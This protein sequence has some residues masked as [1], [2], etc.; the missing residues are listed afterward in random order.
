MQQNLFAAC[1]NLSRQFS[2]G[3]LFWH[4]NPPRN[5]STGLL[6]S[7]SNFMLCGANPLNELDNRWLTRNELTRNDFT[8]HRE[9]KAQPLIIWSDKCI[10]QGRLLPCDICSVLS[11][12]AYNAWQLNPPPEPLHPKYETPE[13]LGRI[14]PYPYK[15]LN[16]LALFTIPK[17]ENPC[18]YIYDRALSLSREKQKHLILGSKD[19][20]WHRITADI[21][22]CKML[23]TLGCKPHDEKHYDITAALLN[24]FKFD[25]A[26]ER[27][28]LLRCFTAADDCITRLLT[29]DLEESIPE[30]LK[31]FISS[32]TWQKLQALGTEEQIDTLKR[33]A[34][35]CAENRSAD[36]LTMRFITTTDNETLEFYSQRAENG[37]IHG[38]LKNGSLCLQAAL[39]TKTLQSTFIPDLSFSPCSKVSLL[40]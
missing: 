20:A 37:Q 24:G 35:L 33:N 36:L 38:I 34:K 31:K 6:L 40:S 18:D 10:K 5:Y 13:I 26:A 30:E 39:P 9:A 29:Q 21:T 15:T 16:G 2:S 1:N 32:I 11:I 19:D 25:N 8:V 17:N 28:K 27:L 22:L 14:S 7:G 3:Y 12:E 4:H 23:Y